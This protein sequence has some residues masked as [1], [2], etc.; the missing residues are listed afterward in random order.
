MN[1]C[2]NVGIDF[3]ISK[4]TFMEISSFLSSVRQGGFLLLPH[5]TNPDLSI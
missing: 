3:S 1:K 2:V 5:M 4:K